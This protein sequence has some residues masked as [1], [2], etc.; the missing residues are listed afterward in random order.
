MADSNINVTLTANA[1]QMAAELQ[2][3]QNELKDF[4]KQLRKAS[5]VTEIQRLQASIVSTKNKIDSL[6]K[7]NTQFARSTNTAAYALNDL[8]RIAQDAPYGFIGIQNNIQPLLESFQRLSKEA[9]GSGAALKAMVQGLMGPA[10][11]GLAVGAV[12]SLLVAFGP[13]IADY[14]KGINEA[15]KADE[16]FAKSLSEA[17]VVEP[18]A[19]P[20]TVVKNAAFS[21][22]KKSLCNIL[23]KVWVIKGND[24]NICLE[25]VEKPAK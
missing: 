15:T 5:D 1:S 24:F 3:A 4:E 18:V 25:K 19:A 13:K 17:V 8:S 20:D 11:I 2:K 16:K 22:L 7:S 23:G 21:A 14:I 10:G 9:G 12:S 6:G